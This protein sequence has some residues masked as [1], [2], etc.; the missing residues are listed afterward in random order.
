MTQA[1]ET[2]CPL[3]SILTFG[4]QG[5]QSWPSVRSP[6][7]CEDFCFYSPCSPFCRI[8]SSKFLF[9]PVTLGEEKLWGEG[10]W[11]LSCPTH[12]LHTPMPP[13]TCRFSVHRQPVLLGLTYK[14]TPTP[15]LKLPVAYIGCACVRPLGVT[16][17]DNGELTCK[18]L[19]TSV[20][21]GR[22]SPAEFVSI[23]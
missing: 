9:C 8:S 18:A 6:E 11:A 1:T 12:S 7:N 16:F 17:I 14:S 23:G 2:G 15:G 21:R 19:Q 5:L 3:R 13:S 22:E 10:G 4:E 20:Q